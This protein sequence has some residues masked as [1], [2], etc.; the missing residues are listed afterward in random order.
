MRR[1]HTAPFSEPTVGEFELQAQA[2]ELAKSLGIWCWH[3]KDSRRNCAGLPDLLLVGTREVWVEL[4]AEHGVL[5]AAQLEV[6]DR[7]RDAGAEVRVYS[8]SNWPRLVSL[9]HSLAP[10]A[11]GF[12][13]T[14]AQVSGDAEHSGGPQ[15]QAGRRLARVAELQ[16]AGVGKVSAERTAD[17]E[18]REEVARVR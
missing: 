11:P 7:L 16:A 3:D 1:S 14:A 17:R 6:H 15:A 5:S 12:A 2:V 18:L 8:P 4:K 13:T 9:L 10:D